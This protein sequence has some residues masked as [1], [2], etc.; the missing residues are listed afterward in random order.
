MP[1]VDDKY[2]SPTWSNDSGTKLNASEMQAITDTI[3]RNQDY[4]IEKVAG[5]LSGNFPIFGSDGAI[6]DSGLSKEYTVG[7]LAGLRTKIDVLFK[8]T[9]GQIWDVQTDTQAAYTKTV[10]SGAVAAEIRSIVGLTVVAD[11]ALVSAAV[12]GVVSKDAD[13]ETLDTLEI[14][15]ALLTFLNDKG[16][17]LSTGNQSYP[18]TLDLAN[19]VYTQNVAAVDLGTLTY[20]KLTA[21][22]PDVF[23]APLP[24][25]AA[26][27][28]I[29]CADY[30]TSTATTWANFGDGKI[31]YNLRDQSV[32]IC[33]SSYA[34]K[35]VAEFRAAMA[36]KIAI[37]PIVPVEYDISAYLSDAMLTVE[38]GGTLT[39]VQ[40][41]GAE[42]EVPSSVDYFVKLAEVV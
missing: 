22:R 5:A 18:N 29:L 13:A 9:Q 7:S 39:F 20:T 16:Y 19:G 30:T 40:E 15:A 35:T 26:R 6:M 12:T 10:P 23:N 24:G 1:I 32:S 41:G 25:H 14:P 42:L 11:G 21:S 31:A 4:K 28:N 8:L 33:D 2:V 36:G 37:Y 38:A 34:E 27:R 3:Q 17:G